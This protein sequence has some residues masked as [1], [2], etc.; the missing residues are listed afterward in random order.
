ML[1]SNS[2]FSTLEIFGVMESKEVMPEQSTTPNI[3]QQ[4]RIDKYLRSSNNYFIRVKQN[5]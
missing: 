4:Y 3:S 2:F 5:V 1:L